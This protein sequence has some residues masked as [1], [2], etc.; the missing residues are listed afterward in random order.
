MRGDVGR[1]HRGV[2]RALGRVGSDLPNVSGRLR[3]REIAAEMGVLGFAYARE[4]K[5]SVDVS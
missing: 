2:G 5:Q 1:G 4:P 3:S